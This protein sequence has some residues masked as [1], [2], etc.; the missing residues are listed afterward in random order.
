MPLSTIFQ[1]YRGGHFIGGGNRRTRRKPP[2]CPSHWH[3]LYHI[4]LYTLPWSR[5]ELTTSVVIGTDCI[6]SCKSNYHTIMAN[7][8]PYHKICLM[9]MNMNLKASSPVLF[10][11]FLFVQDKT[12]YHV[13]KKVSLKAN[14]H[15]CMWT[16]ICCTYCLFLCIIFHKQ[17]HNISSLR[18]NYSLIC[19]CLE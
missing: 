2:T 3:T 14:M 17:L 11:C 6:G 19:Y 12:I 18:N 5:F 15:N 1:L 8:G 9:P 7:D 16:H 10:S 13:K 4:M